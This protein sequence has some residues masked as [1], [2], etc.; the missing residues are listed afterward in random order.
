VGGF[1]SGDTDQDGKLDVTE[2]WHYTA[3]HTVTQ[4]ELDS[5]A[6]IVNT[7][8]V[9]GTNATS[10]DDSASIA[11][12]QNKVLHIV[13]TAAV[14]DGTANS[15]SDVIN[16]T[17]D[18]TNTGNAAI[19]GVVVNDPFTTN[20]APVLVGGFNSGDTDQDGKLDVTETWH[21][22][23]S[24]T[25][26]QAEL[27]SGANIVNTATVT[28]TNATSDDDSA[29][30]AVVQSKSLH[31]VKTGAVADGTANSTSD[32]INY[33]LTVT[34]TGNAAIA[35]VVVND[36][37]TTNEAPVL[38]GG[39]NS[40]DTDQDGKLDVTE[41][42]H[43]TASH[44]VTQAELDSGANI[45]N[46]ATVTGTNATSDDDS[47]SVA[48]VQSPNLT[49]TKT[50]NIAGDADQ[51]VDSAADD[52]TYTIRVTNTGNVTLTGLTVTDPLDPVAGNI[53]GDLGGVGSWRVP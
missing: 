48:V 23:A 22:T 32:V 27:D 31:I 41:T 17:L 28:G 20:E 52:I 26:T 1:N 9:T 6:N 39:F 53:V 30:I 24:H 42:W 14:A 7:A 43:Y 45:V 13:K 46:T 8:T 47:F 49:I 4:A 38:V 19:A 50:A 35:N 21:Y 15:T 16:Y 40:G 11:V 36:P 37:F 12:V 51:K 3:S 10:D 5:G 18:V 25:V 2:T 29:S 34:N 44:T 33:T